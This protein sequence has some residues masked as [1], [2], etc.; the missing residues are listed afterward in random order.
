MLLSVPT[1]NSPWLLL[2]ILVVAHDGVAEISVAKQTSDSK[3]V[4]FSIVCGEAIL[5]HIPAVVSKIEKEPRKWHSKSGPLVHLAEY[6][7]QGLAAVGRV[8]S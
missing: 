1:S 4:T 7:V 2:S 8:I 5:P 6:W 3:G